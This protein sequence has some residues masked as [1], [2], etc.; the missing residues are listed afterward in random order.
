M[1]L[2]KLS[3]VEVHLG[4]LECGQLN[5]LTKFRHERRWV[6]A[7][8]GASCG[9]LEAAIFDGGPDHDAGGKSHGVRGEAASSTGDREGQK[10]T[11][12]DVELA[13]AKGTEQAIAEIYQVFEMLVRRLR[14]AAEKESK[15]NK[16]PRRRRTRTRER[17]PT[18]R[19]RLM[20]KP[21]GRKRFTGKPERG[22][23]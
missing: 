4:R 6:C 5:S 10:D 8:R 13:F 3:Q 20:R 12:Q 11:A 2:Q 19:R 17:R 15:F 14:E 21:E 16:M 1:M 9:L 7:V 18:G 22:M 23:R